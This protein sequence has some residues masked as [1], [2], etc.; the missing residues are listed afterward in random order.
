MTLDEKIDEILKHQ[1]WFYRLSIIRG[2]ISVTLFIILV[3]LPLIGFYFWF[4][5][6]Q[7]NFD[8]SLGD[9]NDTLQQVK[10]VTDLSALDEL[11]SFLNE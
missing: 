2:L 10:E 6:F 3:I 4:Q 11:K 5:S 7:K 1:R 9:V 8:M